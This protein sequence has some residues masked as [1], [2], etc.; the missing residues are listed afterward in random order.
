MKH[1]SHLIRVGHT[2][3]IR[4]AHI[5]TARRVIRGSLKKQKL[6]TETAP[7]LSFVTDY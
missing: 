3:L 4:S 2:R 1:S 6:Q 5:L 7:C